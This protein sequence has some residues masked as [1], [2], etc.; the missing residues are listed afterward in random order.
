MFTLV[1][2]GVAIDF[3]NVFLVKVNLLVAYDA[4]GAS[5]D[6]EVIFNSF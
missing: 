1:V 2:I 5:G 6:D 3:P 4:L